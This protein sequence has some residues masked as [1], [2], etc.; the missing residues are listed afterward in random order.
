MVNFATMLKS[1]QIK[2]I[3]ELGSNIGLNGIAL[4]DLIKIFPY[5][6]WN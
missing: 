5:W 2:S 6:L 4:K 1:T 3:V